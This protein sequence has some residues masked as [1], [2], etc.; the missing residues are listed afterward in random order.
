MQRPFHG[1]SSSLALPLGEVKRDVMS[2]ST[3]P[4]CEQNGKPRRLVEMPTQPVLTNVELVNQLWSDHP[5]VLVLSFDLMPSL[6]MLLL[7]CYF[8]PGS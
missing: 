7:I 1:P 8:V 4:S 5:P 6:L 3:E 2:G